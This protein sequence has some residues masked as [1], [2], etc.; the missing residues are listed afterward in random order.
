MMG[1]G[2]PLARHTNVTFEPSRIFM[3]ELVRDESMSGGTVK[4]NKK[5]SFYFFW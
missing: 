1:C 4:I 3:S 5:M 2:C